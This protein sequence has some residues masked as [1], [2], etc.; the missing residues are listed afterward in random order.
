MYSWQRFRKLISNFK[1]I[2]HKNYKTI[3]Q[4]LVY[5]KNWQVVSWLSWVIL[6]FQVDYSGGFEPF[7]V[8][9]FSQKFVDRVANPKDIIHFFRHRE[10]KE[11]TGKLVIFTN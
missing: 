9:R 5:F 2:E 10:Q 8:L 11:K 4:I 1:S 3:Y 6:Y 7:N